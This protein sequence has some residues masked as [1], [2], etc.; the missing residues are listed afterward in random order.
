MVSASSCSFK[1]CH[2]P[3]AGMRV[4]LAAH[5]AEMLLSNKYNSLCW[6][7][8]GLCSTRKS[9]WGQGKVRTA[10]L[11]EVAVLACANL[12]RALGN[13]ESQARQI[14]SW[15]KTESEILQGENW[16][17]WFSCL[18]HTYWAILLRNYINSSNI[19]SIDGFIHLITFWFCHLVMIGLS[20]SCLSSDLAF[21]LPG[22]GFFCAN[23]HFLY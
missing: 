14:N 23:V 6:R 3:C 13:L 18:F 1:F 22:F 20:F 8:R 19:P 9:N 21:G 11:L 15:F 10:G 4:C 17:H 7:E 12:L 16:N 5:P 2:L